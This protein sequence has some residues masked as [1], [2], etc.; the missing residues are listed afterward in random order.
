MIDLDYWFR[1]LGH[2]DA[3]YIAEALAAFRVSRGSWSIRI[4][5]AQNREFLA[6]VEEYARRTGGSLSGLDRLRSTVMANVNN[7]G[8]LIF[9]RLY[10]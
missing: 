9:Y 1:L 7:L 8:R 4:G 6:F 2:G 3:F 10:A 5:T